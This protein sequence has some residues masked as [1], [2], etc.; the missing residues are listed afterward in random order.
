MNYQQGVRLGQLHQALGISPDARISVNTSQR[1]TIIDDLQTGTRYE[2]P[3]ADPT[4]IRR[5]PFEVPQ[6]VKDIMA[7]SNADL[8]KRFRSNLGSPNLDEM[9][10]LHSECG[11]R[12]IN[13]MN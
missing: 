2:I 10:A 1:A 9:A 8:V 3:V 12:G 6:Y 7:L 13:P 11:F 4:N 5:A